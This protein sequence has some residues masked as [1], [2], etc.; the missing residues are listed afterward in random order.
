ML[1]HGIKQA[2]E[3]KLAGRIRTRQKAGDQISGSS[4]FPFL[5]REMG[6]ID[7]GTIGFVAVKKPF[8]EEAIEGG[9]H[10]G[11]GEGPA[12][13]GDD[14]A[15]TGFALG[16][17]DLHQFKFESAESRGLTLVA[18]SMHTIFQEANHSLLF[19]GALPETRRI[20]SSLSGREKRKSGERPNETAFRVKNRSANT[21]YWGVG[22]VGGPGGYTGAERK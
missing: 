7:E 18:T 1:A 4:A 9:H 21:R 11:V 15:D 2:R 13:L 22:R 17:Q 5:V 16:P 19:I 20:V 8:F 6:R 14:V 12:Q 3:K 10:G